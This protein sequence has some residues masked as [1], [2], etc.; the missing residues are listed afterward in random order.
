MSQY[1]NNLAATGDT[2][3]FHVYL[4]LKK[5]N[6]PTVGPLLVEGSWCDD[7]GVMV[8]HLADYLS[9]VFVISAE[10][11]HRIGG[12]QCP[13]RATNNV[14]IKT[15]WVLLLLCYYGSV[16]ATSLRRQ[17]PSIYPIHHMWSVD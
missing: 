6:R 3:R 7:C 17:L 14:I 2:K 13:S 5:V 4:H 10:A 15:A 8:N 9:S 12:P 16:P 11:S 1:E